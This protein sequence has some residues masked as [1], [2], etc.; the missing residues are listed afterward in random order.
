MLQ[1]LD[2][3]YLND[4]PFFREHNPSSEIIARYIF[5]ELARRLE[6]EGLR[7]HRVTAWES[8]RACASYVKD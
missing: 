8:E 1:G 5:E 7:M 6:R 3:T 4:L 2:H